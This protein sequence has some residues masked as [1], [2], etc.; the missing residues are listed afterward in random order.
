MRIKNEVSLFWRK[1]IETE[2]KIKTESIT[3]TNYIK[4]MY[5]TFLENFY[6]G[7]SAMIKLKVFCLAFPIGRKFSV[8]REHVISLFFGTTSSF[9]GVDYLFI[10]VRS[11][12]TQT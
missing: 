4:L 6:P 10:T 7:I 3:L 8:E 1:K 12:Q 9:T 5:A 11:S 2:T